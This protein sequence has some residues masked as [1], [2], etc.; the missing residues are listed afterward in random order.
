MRKAWNA[1]HVGDCAAALLLCTGSSALAQDGAKPVQYRYLTI[2]YQKT[3]PGKAR[4]YVQLEKESYKPPSGAGQTG[5]DPLVE[6]LLSRFPNGERN[7]YDFVV[8]TEFACFADMDASYA[9]WTVVKS[10]ATP[11]TPKSGPRRRPP[12]NSFVRI[13][14]AMLLSTE[15]WDKAPNKFLEVHFLKSL[16]ENSATCSRYSANTTC[17][18]MRNS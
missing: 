9:A 7:E 1:A 12:A 2:D 5:P 16:P 4:D 11:S 15:N 13:R 8:L 18:P 14:V 10:W 6:A 17:L 3:E